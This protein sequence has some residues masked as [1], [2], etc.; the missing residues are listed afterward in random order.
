HPV[1]PLSEDHALSVGVFT[2]RGGAFFGFYADPDA[3]PEV[4]ELP[5]AVAAEVAALAEAEPPPQ[6]RKPRRLAAV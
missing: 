6:T 4:S 1:V 2:Y 3:L 5:D